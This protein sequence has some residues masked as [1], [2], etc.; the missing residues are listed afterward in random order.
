MK[1]QIEVVVEEGQDVDGSPKCIARGGGC[2]VVG[3]TKE[4]VVAV[5][6]QKLDAGEEGVFHAYVERTEEERAAG[7]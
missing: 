5:I 3:R 7:A 4:A 1:K 6:R 2:T